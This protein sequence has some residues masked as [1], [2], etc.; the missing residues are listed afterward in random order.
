MLF[1]HALQV[2]RVSILPLSATRLAR[3]LSPSIDMSSSRLARCCHDVTL[4]VHRLGVL[5]HAE[6]GRWLFATDICERA[7]IGARSA[8]MFC[9]VVV[10]R[11]FHEPTQHLGHTLRGAML[12]SG[13]TRHCGLGGSFVM[14]RY[15]LGLHFAL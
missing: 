9:C 13:D 14:L 5:R 8:I 1:W 15:A 11:L 6:L 7:K 2:R 3:Y 4:K 12:A 10:W